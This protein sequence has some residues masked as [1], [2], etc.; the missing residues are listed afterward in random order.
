MADG[1]HVASAAGVWRALVF[2]FGGVREYHGALSI[3][4][5]L[6]TP[7]D[8]L[9]FSL[10]FRG[11]RLQIRLTHDQEIY[12]VEHGDPLE[13]TIQGERHLLAPGN[14]LTRPAAPSQ[15]LGSSARPAP[16]TAA[17]T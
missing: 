16:K 7:W 11:R 14:P 5:H 3:T 1:V 10:R 13:L 17:Q 15:P 8:S 9:S 2:G 12:T 4:P 6:P